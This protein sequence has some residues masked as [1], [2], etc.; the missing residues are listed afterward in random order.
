MSG[1]E[2]V[3]AAYHFPKAELYLRYGGTSRANSSG[4]ID[5][6]SFA[7]AIHISLISP[8]TTFRP[9]S[10]SPSINRAHSA[11]R[12]RRFSRDVIARPWPKHP[13]R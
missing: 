13:W 12:L 8:N 7:K 5:A 10:A 1:L 4:L 11:A 2:K 3:M 6:R 9:L